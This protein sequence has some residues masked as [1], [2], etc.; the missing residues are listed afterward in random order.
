MRKKAFEMF[1]RRTWCTKNNLVIEVFYG[2]VYNQALYFILT[3]YQSSTV[4]FLLQVRV[5]ILFFFVGYYKCF[6]ITAVRRRLFY[7]VRLASNFIF[8]NR[9]SIYQRLPTPA[10]ILNDFSD[11]CIQYWYSIYIKDGI[12][13]NTNKCSVIKQ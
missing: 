7:T 6:K 4:D 2:R 8:E 11:S 10:V 13:S 1:V 12:Y 5:K 9:P 3:R